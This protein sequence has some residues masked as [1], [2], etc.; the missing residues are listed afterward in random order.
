MI[1]NIAKILL[2]LT[3]LLTSANALKKDEIKPQMTQKINKVLLILKEKNIS[4]TQKMKKIVKIIDDVFDYKVMARISLGKTW[5]TISK[6]EKEDFSEL[7]EK[8]L[9]DSY[10][11]KLKLY[12]NQEVKIKNL[13]P[14]RKKRLQLNTEIIGKGEI[15]KVVYKFY[16]KKNNWLIYDVDLIGVSIIQTYKKQFSSFLK[17]KTFSQLLENLKNK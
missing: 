1:K 3:L 12:T 11:D 15:N 17:E 5:K 10:L 7:L 13:E 16:N 8:K 9:K 2:S 4:D 6:K 14:Y